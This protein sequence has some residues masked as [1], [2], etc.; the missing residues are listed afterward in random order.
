MSFGCSKEPSYLDSSFEY[1]QH[2]FW[3]RKYFVQPTLLSGGLKP[4][5]DT[6]WLFYAPLG[7]YHFGSC[8]LLL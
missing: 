5:Y 8:L 3:F 1:P 4:Q 2:M 7:A 6:T